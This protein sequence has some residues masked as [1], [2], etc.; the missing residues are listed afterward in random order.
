M[1]RVLKRNRLSKEQLTN[2]LERQLSQPSPSRLVQTPAIPTVLET[3]NGTGNDTAPDRRTLS[4]QEKTA[5]ENIPLS[6]EVGNL[7]TRDPD[8]P[9][10][11][12]IR[13]IA[14]LE[15][16]ARIN[17]ER[18]AKDL[19]PLKSSDLRRSARIK[20]KNVSSF[21]TFVLPPG[22]PRVVE[23]K[24]A[25]RAE[26]EGLESR[27]VFRREIVPQHKRK[28]LN[29]LRSRYVHA[30]KNVG[31]PDQKHKSR[32][33]VQAV[34]RADRDSPS[35][36][37]YSP[38]TTRSSTRLLL[39]TAASMDWEVR[40][41]DISQAFVSS[42]Y[43]LLREVY[44]VPPKEANRPKDELWRLLKPLYGLPESSLLW[45]ST[46]AGHLCAIVGLECDSI[47]PC[48]FY[49]SIS[50]STT[51]HGLLTMQV[52][53]TL[54]AGTKKFLE[55]EEQHAHRFPT[56]PSTV[57][58]SKPVQ[59]NGTFLSRSSHGFLSSQVSY[60]EGITELETGSLAEKF[61]SLRGKIAYATNQTCPVQTCRL[62]MLSQIPA[63]DATMADLKKLRRILKELRS[64]D[65]T[66]LLFQKLDLSTV[67]LRVYT[68]A[69][70]ANNADLSSQLGWCIFAVDATGRCN[71]LH[72]SSRKC[73]RVVKST[74]AAELFALVQG[75]DNGMALKHSIS[76]ILGRDVQIAIYID[77]KGVW[78][79]VV[80]LR[81][82]TEKRL[83]IDIACLRQS[84]GTGELKSF[85][86]IDTALNPADAFTKERPC[87]AFQEVLDSGRLRHPVLISLAHGRLS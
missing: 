13:M 8:P 58:D 46:Y 19:P 33:V 61:A 15:E 40:T 76:A 43:D 65:S 42:E 24:E 21:G 73:R 6:E 68:D 3:D 70:F 18:L 38:T 12:E 36:F 48:L 9:D 77:S 5:A 74:F 52:D 60:I 81:S 22:D 31:M 64:G 44:I 1:S 35:L 11:E 80:S 63:K 85:Y 72:W 37:K 51:D 25:M 57:I 53:D 29:I 69:S 23:F 66:G 34:K 2:H 54:L 84:F 55:I 56:K 83:L 45:Y 82:L 62:N 50:N 27:D 49:K 17:Q 4:D 41:R 39:S 26:D 71:L 86:C 87:P 47:D 30:I 28:G 7:E 10:E 32:L 78:D 20:E 59:F 16:L 67:E 14:E 75:Y 79:A